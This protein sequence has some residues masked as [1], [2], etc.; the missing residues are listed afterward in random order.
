MKIAQVENEHD[1][2]RFLQSLC[3]CQTRTELTF[4]N[5]EGTQL[6]DEHPKKKKINVG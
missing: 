6:E 3:K 2:V 5:E 4:L 1:K